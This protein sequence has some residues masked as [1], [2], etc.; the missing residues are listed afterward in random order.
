M[1]EDLLNELKT[2]YEEQRARNE[3]EETERR[4]KIRRE[5]PMIEKKVEE[6]EN[7]VFDTIRQILDGNAKA[8]AL[9]EKMIQLNHDIAQILI[10]N[11]FPEDYLEPVYRCSKC[12]DTGYTGELNQKPCEC[13]IK[14]YQEKVR[15]M[16][17]LGKNKD[18]TF[19]TY[20]E[21]LIPDEIAGES[22]VT[23]RQLSGFARRECEKWADKYP[24][25]EKRDILLSGKSG[26]GKTFLMR[27]MAARLIERGVNVLMVSAYTFLQIARRSYFDSEDGIKEL[28]EVPVLMLDD[29]GSEPLMQNITVEQLFYL[30]NERQTKNLS[31]V[32]ST[33]LT[34]KE[35]RERYTERIASRLTDPRNCEVI[36]LEGRDLRKTFR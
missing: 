23:Q 35:F 25:V 16:I 14:A 1:R 17:G 32:I 11:N 26:L 22:G 3:R 21:L 7:L 29:V 8:E 20:D 19:E 30:I 15:E 13:L 24:E 12:K 27:A 5:F 4:E 9:K 34:M 33:N 18:E 28:M 10:E 36:I 2:E 31:T 6:R